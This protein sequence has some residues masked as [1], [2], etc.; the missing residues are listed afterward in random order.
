[1]AYERG[2]RRDAEEVGGLA[3]ARRL[4]DARY[5]AAARLY[6]A[7]VDPARRATIVVE[8]DDLDNP[9]LRVSPRP[10]SDRREPNGR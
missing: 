8:N 1:M 5:H 9:R 7:A 10:P 6:I 2:T 4:Y 3:V